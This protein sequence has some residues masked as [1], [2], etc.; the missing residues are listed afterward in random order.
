MP[1]AGWKL[2]PVTVSRGILKQKVI[3]GNIRHILSF[4]TMKKRPE[5]ETG[6]PDKQP[7]S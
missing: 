2:I 3:K 4:I 1:A 7:N 6:E 5:E